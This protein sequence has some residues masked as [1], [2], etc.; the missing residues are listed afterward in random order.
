MDEELHRCPTCELILP[1]SNF[2]SDRTASSGLH[3]KCKACV[4][5]YAA[6]V[7]QRHVQKN[8][9][10]SQSSIIADGSTK[11]CAGCKVSKPRSEFPVDRHMLGGYYHKCKACKA[12][13]GKTRRDALKAAKPQDAVEP[14]L[15]VM[16]NSLLP[17]L[18]KVGFAI[19]PS[20]RAVELSSSHPFDLEVCYEYPKRGHLEAIIHDRLRAHRF[21]G[22]RAS[23]GREWFEVRADQADA[24]IRD[25]I[26]EW[27]LANS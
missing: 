23:K 14:A 9:L 13:Y 8:L 24:V 1:V 22:V 2:A 7:R 19:D 21:T 10:K 27:D 16:R 17:H 20:K 26:A 25:T 5:V 3:W 6:T 15:Y 11:K 4:N 18:V 12:V